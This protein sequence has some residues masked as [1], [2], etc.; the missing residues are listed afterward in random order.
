[1]RSAVVFIGGDPPS[2]GVVARLPAERI[3]IA[4]DSGLTHAYALGVDVD[5]L[6]GDLDSVTPGEVARARADGVD[7]EQHPINKDATD[8]ELAIDAALNRSCDHLVVVS[9]GGGRFDHELGALMAMSRP[10]LNGIDVEAWWGATYMRVIHGPD[11]QTFDGRPGAVVSL[12]ALHGDVR[13][14]RALG[15]RYPLP[16][17]R[18]GRGPVAASATSSWE[19]NSVSA[20]RK[21]PCSSSSLEPRIGGSMTKHVR[22]ALALATPRRCARCV[23]RRRRPA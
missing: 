11:A 1:M 20:S 13:E 5:L 18:C 7:V 10:S 17:R 16:R 4:A 19:T 9:G 12:I 23:Q 22:A 21:G 6:I 2:P 3:V 14:V 8:T 15:L